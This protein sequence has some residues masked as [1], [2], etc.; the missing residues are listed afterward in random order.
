MPDL[1]PQDSLRGLASVDVEN[2]FP[3]LEY[4]SP[5]DRHTIDI[6]EQGDVKEAEEPKDRYNS[7]LVGICIIAAVTGVFCLGVNTLSS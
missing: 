3:D 7:P 2:D 4:V 5:A 6:S 1:P